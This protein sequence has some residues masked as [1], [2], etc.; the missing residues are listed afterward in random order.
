M[1]F[2][3]AHFTQRNAIA[4]CKSEPSIFF[5]RR[6]RQSQRDKGTQTSSLCA[7]RSFTALRPD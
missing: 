7:Q 6:L 2:D 5:I 4:I 3:Y 1:L